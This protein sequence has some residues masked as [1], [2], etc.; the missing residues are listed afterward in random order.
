MSRRP[1]NDLLSHLLPRANRHMARRLAAEGA[2]VDQWRVMK[3][4]SDRQGMTMGSVAED[5]LLNA[6]TAAKLLDRMVQEA[7]VYRAPDPADR[8]RPARKRR[9]HRAARRGSPDLRMCCSP[10]RRGSWGVRRLEVYRRATRAPADLAAGRLRPRRD[11]APG[12]GRACA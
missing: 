5:L 2:P 8:R 7:L 6:P 4:L 12:S 11:P 10:A 9:Q 3:A 1:L